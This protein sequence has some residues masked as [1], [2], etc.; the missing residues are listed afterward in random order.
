[1]EL[2]QESPICEPC[3][4]VS[5][6]HYMCQCTNSGAH[7][8]TSLIQDSGV[9]TGASCDDGPVLV[10]V[11]L[12]PTTGPLRDHCALR[13]TQVQ[14]PDQRFGLDI[15]SLKKTQH[16][17]LLSPDADTPHY[18][19]QH[20]LE[21]IFGSS[22]FCEQHALNGTKAE[23]LG[24]RAATFAGFL[25]TARS[26]SCRRARVPGLKYPTVGVHTLGRWL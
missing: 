13:R 21:A 14:V 26:R 3:I 2:W 15:D 19:R 9:L 5:Q 6:T 17:V 10:C 4:H 24:L 8:T 11:R 1:M 23:G 18:T 22:R 16:N 20:A 7:K 25:E 12:E